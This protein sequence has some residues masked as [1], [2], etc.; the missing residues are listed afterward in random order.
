MSIEPCFNE[1]LQYQW[2]PRPVERFSY[3]Q[4]D[5]L[6]VHSFILGFL[7]GLTQSGEIGISTK[8]STESMLPVVQ[9]LP[10]F[11]MLPESSVDHS[12][13]NLGH[14]TGKRNRPEIGRFPPS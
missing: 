6:G 14:A 13:K 12:L 4:L 7:E 8:T 2:G 5:D 11:Q 3:V 9:M 10:N 1:T